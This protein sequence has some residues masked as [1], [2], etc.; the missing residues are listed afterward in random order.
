MK[1][2]GIVIAGLITLLSIVPCGCAQMNSM[3][4]RNFEAEYIEIKENFSAEGFESSDNNDHMF[5]ALPTNYGIVCEPED[6][7]YGQRTLTYF[8]PKDMAV[9]YLQLFPTEAKNSWNSNMI[10]DPQVFSNS[11]LSEEGMLSQGVS[12]ISFTYNKIHYTILSIADHY[13][14]DSEDSAEANMMYF[15]NELLLFLKK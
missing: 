6:Y 4:E 2:E 12:T 13:G 5:V 10:F 14:C 7:E 11:G 8:N 9:V 15:T 3:S 1:K